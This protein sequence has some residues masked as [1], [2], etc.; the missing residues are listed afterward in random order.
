VALDAS[1]SKVRVSGGD[2]FEYELEFIEMFHNP[3]PRH[4]NK[5]FL[6]SVVFETRQQELKEVGD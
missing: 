3:K 5:S 1:A 2:A 4:T 6:S